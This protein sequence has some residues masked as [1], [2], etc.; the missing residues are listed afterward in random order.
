M[1]LLANDHARKEAAAIL[2]IPC[3]R[4]LD[5]TLRAL[6]SLA[7]VRTTPALVYQAMARG[8]LTAQ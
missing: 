6:R 7:G 4:T 8:W 2:G 3:C 5:T 1:V